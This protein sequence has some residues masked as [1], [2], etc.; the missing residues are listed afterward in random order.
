MSTA[1]IFPG[2][3]S[4]TIGMGKELHNN[5]PVAKQVFAEV[6]DALGYKLSQIIFNGPLDTLT[7]TE[8]TQPALMATSIAFVKVIE[9]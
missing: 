6:D 7:K 5:Y 9:S 3:G 8:N 4:Q 1:F 2:Q